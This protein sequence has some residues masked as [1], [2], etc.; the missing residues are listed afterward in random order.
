MGEKEEK[1]G[2]WRGG[3]ESKWEGGHER[4]SERAEIAEGKMENAEE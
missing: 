4:E 1:E 2:D 3:R